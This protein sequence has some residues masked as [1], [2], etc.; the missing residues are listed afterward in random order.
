MHLNKRDPAL[1]PGGENLPLAAANQSIPSLV[2]IVVTCQ[3][4]TGIRLPRLNDYYQQ[5][6]IP[7]AHGVCFW[8][9]WTECLFYTTAAGTKRLQKRATRHLARYNYRWAYLCINTCHAV[10]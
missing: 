5:H 8:R 3:F 9:I 7:A 1:T 2:G 6:R 10:T 4:A